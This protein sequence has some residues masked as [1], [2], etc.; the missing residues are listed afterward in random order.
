MG[1]N[2]GDFRVGNT[3]HIMLGNNPYGATRAEVTY[4]SADTPTMQGTPTEV[5][6]A[7]G[8]TDVIGRLVLGGNG[9]VQSLDVNP[10]KRRKG[11]AK[12]MWGIVKTAAAT[13]PSAVATPRHS[14]RRSELGNAF[15]RSTGDPVPKRNRAFQLESKY[16]GY[17]TMDGAADTEVYTRQ[18]ASLNNLKQNAWRKRSN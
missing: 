9:V 18:L 5:Q 1:A 14:S 3:E 17:G 16:K 11:A 15:A 7:D 13:S 8:Q 2:N 4:G 12:T 10:D 6:L